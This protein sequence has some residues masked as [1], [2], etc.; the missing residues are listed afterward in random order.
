GTGWGRIP[1]PLAAEG[2]RE[3]EEDFGGDEGQ[4]YEYWPRGFRWTC[5]GT[6]GNAPWGCDHHGT[7]AFHLSS[8]L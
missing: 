4:Y 5:C 2:R 6:G 1:S 8:L 7:G 3:F